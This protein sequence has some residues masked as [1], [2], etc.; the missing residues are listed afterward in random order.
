MEN[1]VSSTLTKEL[2]N[3][4]RVLTISTNYKIDY[5]MINV[6]KDNNDCI[7]SILGISTKDNTKDIL[8]VKTFKEKTIEELV[9]K[10]YWICVEFNVRRVLCDTLGYSIAF[11]DCFVANINPH[12]LPIIAMKMVDRGA[13]GSIYKQIEKDLQIGTLRFLQDVE[14]AKTF[15]KESF[16]GYSEVISFH[17]ETDDLINQISSVKLTIKNGYLIFISDKEIGKSQLVNLLMY[18]GFPGNVDNNV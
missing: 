12:D 9:E 2:I 14:L 4:N 17:K 13:F 1:T 11:Y 15:Y 5:L 6:D 10:V 3:K 16:L 7:G 8:L 18:Y